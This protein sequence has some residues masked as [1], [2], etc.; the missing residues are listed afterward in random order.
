[1]P[2]S[3]SITIPAE[4]LTDASPSHFQE[5]TRAFCGSGTDSSWQTKQYRRRQTAHSCPTRDRPTSVRISNKRSVSV[6]ARVSR[7]SHSSTTSARR[8]QSLATT[9]A[10]ASHTAKN[11]D[12]GRM[13]TI[14]TGIACI[15]GITVIG[16][17]SRA[18]GGRAI[19]EWRHH[20]AK[21][22]PPG[23][24]RNGRVRYRVGG[25]PMRNV[26]TE[27]RSEP[28][29]EEPAKLVS[30][31]RSKD[32]ADLALLQKRRQAHLVLNA[33]RVETCCKHASSF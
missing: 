30:H 32:I 29:G 15:S 17:R 28:P 12:C 22:E 14:A 8:D 6:E 31:V 27:V 10:C 33:L 4:R 24:H 3:A 13:V 18:R 21:D 11:S 20:E 26:V 5:R 2:T 7:R 9:G 19:P 25:E 16:R 1:M 23:V